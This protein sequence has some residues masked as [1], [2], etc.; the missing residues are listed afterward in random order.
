MT[1]NIHEIIWIGIY[2]LPNTLN[3]VTFYINDNSKKYVFSQNENK[4][5]A[6]SMPFKSL[7]NKYLVF[8]ECSLNEW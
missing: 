4:T 8:Y 1:R 7:R 3:I 5:S 6:F 2:L